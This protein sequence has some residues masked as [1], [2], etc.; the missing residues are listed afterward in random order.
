MSDPMSRPE[1]RERSIGETGRRAAASGRPSHPPLVAALLVLSI[2][3]FVVVL[4][5]ASTY[6]L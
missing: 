2:T 1:I 6:G 4:A 3:L 5:L